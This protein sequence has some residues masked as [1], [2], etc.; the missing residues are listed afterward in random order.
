MDSKKHN[1]VIIATS[2]APQNRIGAIRSSKIAK[3]LV[4]KGHRVTVIAPKIDKTEQIDQTLNIEESDGLRVLR[5][6][7]GV[8]FERTLKL[9]RNRMLK[10]R[11]AS[12]YSSKASNTNL[13]LIGR[14]LKNGISFY[15]YLENVLWERN[16]I[17]VILRN[18]ILS[19]DSV[20]FSSYPKISAHRVALYLKKNGYC[21]TWISDY[22]DPLIYDELGSEQKKNII[23]QKEFSQTADL[24][25]YVS[26][27]MIDKLALGISDFDKFKYLPNGFDND[28][29]DVINKTE[30]DRLDTT[31]LNISYVGGLYNGKRDLSQLFKVIRNLID[32]GDV[33][34]KGI[35]FYYAG[36]EFNVLRNQAS[37]FNLEEILVNE[38]Y[39][40]REDS[41]AIQDQSDIVVV[42]TWNTEKDVGVIPGK[43]YECF[44][45]KK[46]TITITNGTKP[47]SELGSMVKKSGLGIEVN[48]M[49]E[50][51][52]EEK[53]LKKFILDAY[54]S[55]LSNTEFKVDY[56]TDYINRF[57]YEYIT[58]QLIQLIE[59]LN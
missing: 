26:E 21:K 51:K 56:N 11:S 5:V 12:S 24:I 43:I 46:P 37:K 54:H 14:I 29:L 47:N 44:L 22:R 50:D 52:D 3:N 48:V 7:H 25:T 53:R 27:K 55:T 16:V 1:I 30:I 49:Q 19:Q 17:N 8:I 10:N 4:A 35:R 58:E 23:H 9:I 2:F 33:S 57:N 41:L 18:N 36:K 42:S 40:A 6:S 13:N 34:T 59:G 31:N 38:G 45:L 32:S 28:D 39:V 20:I 15:L